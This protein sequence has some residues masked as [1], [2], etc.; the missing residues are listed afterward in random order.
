MASTHSINSVDS[1]DEFTHEVSYD[2]GEVDKRS[3]HNYTDKVS[4]QW[5][6]SFIKTLQ[7]E[8]AYIITGRN[9]IACSLSLLIIK[10]QSTCSEK[11]I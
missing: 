5:R 1:G 7:D 11:F 9:D 6:I 10:I 4:S 3:L 8:D 2:A